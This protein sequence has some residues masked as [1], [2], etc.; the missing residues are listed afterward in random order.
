MMKIKNS[1]QVFPRRESASDKNEYSDEVGNYLSALMLFENMFKGYYIVFTDLFNMEK[2]DDLNTYIENIF[3]KLQDYVIAT[4]EDLLKDGFI[5]LKKSTGLR[6][7][8]VDRSNSC[9]NKDI[10]RQ[11]QKR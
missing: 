5:E 10:T 7:I 11:T 8:G 2:V 6:I 3:S 1:S 4:N 9:L